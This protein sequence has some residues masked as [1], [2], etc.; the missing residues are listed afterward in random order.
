MEKFI[1]KSGDDEFLRD[2]PH[3]LPSPVEVAHCGRIF[4]QKDAHHV[5]DL[6]SCN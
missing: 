4:Q 5:T 1:Y 2:L 6:A 3:V